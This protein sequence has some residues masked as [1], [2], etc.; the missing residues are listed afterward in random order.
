MSAYAPYTGEAEPIALDGKTKLYEV[1][2][3]C[4]EERV[5]DDEGDRIVRHTASAASDAQL[6]EEMLKGGNLQF[7][8]TL[9][10]DFEWDS[11]VLPR[12]DPGL[13]FFDGGSYSAGPA[14]LG[15]AAGAYDDYSDEEEEEEDDEGAEPSAAA[16]AAGDGSIVDLIP[17]TDDE[18]LYADE[19][20]ASGALS[21]TKRYE[22]LPC[23]HH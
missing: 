7:D 11:E 1:N 22:T 21:G 19:D 20:E 6:T 4:V 5:V 16:A 18:K 12:G 8:P 23:S 10:V 2:S 15:A 3:V 17:A 9:S 14:A 13:Y